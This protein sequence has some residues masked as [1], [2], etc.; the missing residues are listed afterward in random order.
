MHIEYTRRKE[1]LRKQF[2]GKRWIKDNKTWIIEFE[3]PVYPEQMAPASVVDCS[4]F[5]LAYY[6][7]SSRRAL[8]PGRLGHSFRTVG[9]SAATFRHPALIFNFLCCDDG[10]R[11]YLLEQLNYFTTLQSAAMPQED[12]PNPSVIAH[13]GQLQGQGLAVEYFIPEDPFRWSVIDFDL[14][15]WWEYLDDMVPTYREEY[16]QKKNHVTPHGVI[17]LD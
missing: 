2:N 3:H 4:S 10:W 14:P 16:L 7:E 12:W 1:R 15:D 17:P 5:D 6:D 8:A 13:H 9:V 11:D